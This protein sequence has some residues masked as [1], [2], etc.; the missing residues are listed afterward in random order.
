MQH[1]ESKDLQSKVKTLPVKAKKIFLKAFNKSIKQLGEKKALEMAWAVI[2]KMYSKSSGKW[3]LKQ[4][5]E[6]KSTINREGFFW[7]PSYYF[8]IVLSSLSTHYDGV[9]VSEK[10]LKKIDEMDLIDN[11]GDINHLAIDGNSEYAGLFKRVGKEFKEGV[12]SI[13]VAINKTHDKYKEFMSN[14]NN[15][16]YV[17]LSAEFYNPKTFGDLILDADSLGWTVTDN[18][19]DLES[20]KIGKGVL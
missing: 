18:P 16:K 20:K 12:L 14:K 8:D 15:K 19:A 13:K 11:E 4:D 2:K 1:S 10:L 3:V 5:V 6:I 7:N 17:H 9:R